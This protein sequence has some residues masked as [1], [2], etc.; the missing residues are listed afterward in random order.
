MP[1]LALPVL[2]LAGLAL[3]AAAASAHIALVDPPPRHP[4]LKLGPCGAG[5]GDLRGDII[6]TFQGGQTI[7]VK[8]TE[9]VDHPGHY[10]ISFDAD[11]QDD[12]GDPASFDELNSNPAVLVDGIADKQG[13]NQMYEQQITLPEIS[14]DN[15]TLQVIQMMTDKP[16]YGDGNDIY[17]QCADIVIEGLAGTTGGD[18]T[19]GGTT[20]G[21]STSGSTTSA[22]T[23][24]GD[25]TTGDA[26]TG[27]LPG[28]T[29]STTND[30]TTGATTSATTGNDTSGSSGDG[31]GSDDA[32]G[33]GCRSDAANGWALLTL[34]PGLALRRRRPVRTDS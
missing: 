2:A 1:R 12:F 18:T 13:A 27:D 29:G 23:A 33:C 10:R 22:G 20:S 31:P 4:M 17:Y 30:P 21:D 9:T 34:L 8:W 7:V 16:P 15:C 24:T 14:C 19:G 6:T 32:A 5:P 11:G 28:G 25:A 26:T 3:H